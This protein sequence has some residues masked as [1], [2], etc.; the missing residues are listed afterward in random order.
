[1]LSIL[2]A[3]NYFICESLML[4]YQ[5]PSVYMLPAFTGDP[6]IKIYRCD[7]YIRGFGNPC[8]FVVSATI[9]A[10]FLTYEFNINGLVFGVIW[11]IIISLDRMI[12]G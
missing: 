8:S 3:A 9:F 5:D 1:M 6:E 7:Q 4:M 10:S 12:L 11:V 2:I